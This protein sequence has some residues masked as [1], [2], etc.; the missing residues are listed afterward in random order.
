[1]DHH[2][3]KILKRDKKYPNK[4]ENNLQEWRQLYNLIEALNFDQNAL[5]RQKEEEFYPFQRL[6]ISAH[7][8]RDFASGKSIGVNYFQ[9]SYSS[10]AYPIPTNLFS[11]SSM[12]SYLPQPKRKKSAI[13]NGAS[14]AFIYPAPASSASR[15]TCITALRSR[16]HSSLITH[17]LHHG[18]P[19]HGI[20]HP[21]SHI[22]HPVS[23][24]DDNSLNKIS[25]LFCKN[26]K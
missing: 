9:N 7:L 16:N 24:I 6:K 26:M 2:I 20:P 17:H 25:S 19:H 12:F 15:G 10:V 8:V 21:A 1:M 23:H 11:H 5:S 22:T 4:E 14:I 3:D 18:T 13:I